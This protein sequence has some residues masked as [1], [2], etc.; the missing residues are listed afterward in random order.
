M[1]V[2]PEPERAVLRAVAHRDIDSRHDLVTIPDRGHRLGRHGHHHAEDAPESIAHDQARLC[3]LDMDV[4]GACID[5]AGDDVVAELDDRR[6]GRNGAFASVEDL[7][8]CCRSHARDEQIEIP[9]LVVVPLEGCAKVRARREDRVRLAAG[10]ER[11]IALCFVVIRAGD[12]VREHPIVLIERQQPVTARHPLARREGR[13]IHELH[14]GRLRQQ[15]VGVGLVNESEVDDR[16][17]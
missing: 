1:L 3:R 8:V 14:P 4:A 16:V 9:E 11:H 2:D 13:K 10:R 7:D 15:R 12:H 6:L 17:R 5:R